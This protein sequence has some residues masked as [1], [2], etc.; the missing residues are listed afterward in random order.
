MFFEEPNAM[1]VYEESFSCSKRKF[2]YFQIIENSN[3]FIIYS[4]GKLTK[5]DNN[6]ENVII[7]FGRKISENE[8]IDLLYKFIENKEFI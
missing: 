1:V 2:D 3:R 7:N 6:I 8:A 4:N 5:E